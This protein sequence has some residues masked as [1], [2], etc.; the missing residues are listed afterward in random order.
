MTFSEVLK[1]L[2]VLWAFIDPVGSIPV[3]LEATKQF[4]KRTKVKIARKATL[5]AGGVLVFF[6]ILG[7]VVLE[8]MEISLDA[9]QVSGGAILFIF[10]LTMIFGRGKPD[11]EVSMIK[12]YNHVTV[13][14]IAIPSIASPGAI[15]GIVLLTDNNTF[16]ILHQSLTGLLMLVVLV[17]TYL[18]LILSE[19]I[20]NRFGDNSIAVLSKIMGLIIASVAVESI[21][22]GIQQYFSL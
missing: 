10:S 21:L 22:N 11:E 19:K 4:D 13:F 18:L 12:D 9:F 1:T 5:I 14:P 3:F 7:Q 15:M 16:S 20:H 6:L 17:A 8:A 2:V